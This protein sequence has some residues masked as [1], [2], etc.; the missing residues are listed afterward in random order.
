MRRLIILKFSFRGTLA[1]RR[2]TQ[3][4]YREAG[5]KVAEIPSIDA[6]L[7]QTTLLHELARRSCDASSRPEAIHSRKVQ[8]KHL[9][10]MSSLQYSPPDF[11]FTV[12]E[13][14]MKRSQQKTIRALCDL[15]MSGADVTRR[16]IS[17]VKI[18]ADL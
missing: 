15:H 6:W 7:K 5:V 12:Q 17:R 13:E 1:A 3:A 14:R 10:K 9:T 18:F 2:P 11:L 4:A 8:A 16:P